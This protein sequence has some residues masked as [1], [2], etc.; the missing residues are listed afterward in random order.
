MLS[1]PKKTPSMS[2]E[3]YKSITYYELFS[4]EID[5]YT[6]ILP[7]LQSLIEEKL[8]APNYYYSDQ[9]VASASIILGDFNTDGWRVSKDRTGLSLEHAPIAVQNLGRF[10]G[11]CYALKSKDPIQFT[12]LTGRL[13][14]SRYIEYDIDEPTLI[15]EPRFI[16]FEKVVAEYQPE[17]DKEFTKKF[18]NLVDDY[19]DYGRQRVAPQEPI[20]TLC[21]GDYLRNN[22]AFRYD[23]NDQPLDIMMFDYQTL[24]YSSPMIDLT[25][26]LA[27]SVYAKVRHKH[28]DPLFDDY[29]K[30][31]S[32]SY[33]KYSESKLPIFLSRENLLKEYIRCLPYSLSVTCSF[34]S[35]LVDD[36]DQEEELM[37]NGVKVRASKIVD[38]EVAHQ[39][40]EMFD[41]SCKYNVD[42]AEGIKTKS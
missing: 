35:Y 7:K 34:L 22:V 29:C 4:N 1:N 17:V 3:E 36:D 24:R 19:V 2:A 32:E 37:K 25:T 33:Q 39:V 8:E 28:F 40:K 18:I 21:H 23:E 10:H 27:I 30:N 31:L 5:F 16:R 14:E 11:F 41:L 15:T 38:R 9:Q 42:I 6:T 12:E 20:A 26:F 13:K